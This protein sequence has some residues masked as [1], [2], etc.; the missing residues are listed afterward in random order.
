MD[1]S[2]FCEKQLIAGYQGCTENEVS[3]NA[4]CIKPQFVLHFCRMYNR[5]AREIQVTPLMELLMKLHVQ[6][7]AVPCS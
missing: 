5:D 7:S 6:L 4:K 1:A 2:A 3:R